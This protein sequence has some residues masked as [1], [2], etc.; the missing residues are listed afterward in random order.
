MARKGFGGM[1][2]KADYRVAGLSESVFGIQSF[3]IMA[4]NALFEYMCHAS[5]HD[6]FQHGERKGNEIAGTNGGTT[7]YLTNAGRYQLTTSVTE[8]LKG[9]DFLF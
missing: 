2:R 4:R 7:C 1:A 8:V 6:E 3:Q 9:L 5:E